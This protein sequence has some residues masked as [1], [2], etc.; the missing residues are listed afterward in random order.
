M[1]LSTVTTMGFSISGGL[2]AG[3]STLPTLGY[4]IGDSAVPTIPGAEYTMDVDAGFTMSNAR[5]HY[6]MSDERLH[7]RTEEE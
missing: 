2:T 4:G 5:M 3:T 7:Y 1:S 6:R